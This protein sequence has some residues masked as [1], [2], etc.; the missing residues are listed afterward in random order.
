M[1]ALVCFHLSV[2]F[3]KHLSVLC[4]LC[5]CDRISMTSK[6]EQLQFIFDL[7]TI[8]LPCPMHGDATVLCFLSFCPFCSPDWFSSIFVQHDSGLS[9]ILTYYDKID[10]SYV[11]SVFL[12]GEIFN[13]AVMYMFKY[14]KPM[15][16]IT[17]KVTTLLVSLEDVSPL[18]QLASS[19]LTFGW[20]FWKLL[21]GGLA[22]GGGHSQSSCCWNENLSLRIFRD[23]SPNLY[24]E[25]SLFFLEIY[26]HM[27]GWVTQMFEL[28]IL[29]CTMLVKSYLE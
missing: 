22:L 21:S 14:N 19:V 4:C 7:N 15:N 26:S 29:Q 11:F 20:E 17:Q 16:V 2:F 24:T 12:G 23:R 18:I 9:V 3:R 25:L 27:S 8:W 1:C 28:A 5:W 13:N 6:D 10:I